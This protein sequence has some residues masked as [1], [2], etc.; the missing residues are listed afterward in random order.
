MIALLDNSD[1]RLHQHMVDKVVEWSN[2]NAVLINT[3]KTE[4]VVFGVPSK[5]HHSPVHGEHINQVC[6]YKYVGVVIDHGK[7]TF[8]LCVRRQNK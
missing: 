7:I 6:S 2:N 3:T 5:S 1:P 8:D 4:E